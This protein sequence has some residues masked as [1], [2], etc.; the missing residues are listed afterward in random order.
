MNKDEELFKRL[1]HIMGDVQ[2]TKKLQWQNV[3]WAIL[4]NGALIAL[5]QFWKPISTGL[6][7]LEALI[8]ILGAIVAGF[9]AW[10]LVAYQCDHARSLARYR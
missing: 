2:F 1:E 5:F 3:Y 7:R 9:A 10:F 8:R 4:L 6:T